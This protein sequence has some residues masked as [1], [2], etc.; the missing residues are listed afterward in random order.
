M[1][2]TNNLQQTL[3]AGATSLAFIAL[4]V[5]MVEAATIGLLGTTS[6]TALTTFLTNNGN[7]VVNLN[8]TPNFTGLD[9]VIL[10]RNSPTGATSTNLINFVQGGGRLIT[11]FT[12]SQWAL[13]QANLLQAQD[14]GG[15]NLGF[16][17][18]VT[19]TSEGISSGLANGVGVNNS[20][21]DGSR[22]EV[23]RNF[24]ITGSGVDVLATKPSTNPNAIIG[25]ASGLG[26]TLIIGYDWAD[27][28]GSA[29]ADT[30]RL[31][32]NA[33]NYTASTPQ[34]PEPAT[35]TGILV[36]GVAGLLATRKRS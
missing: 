18:P 27:S 2:Q 19:F 1:N 4:P 32:L 9:T 29:N 30:Q 36:F 21:S 26:T 16:S 5:S 13:N 15:S 11:E 6:N 17:T 31:I 23:F 3:L 24:N 34:V 33:L 12:G 14:I 20:Y 7:T 22:T 10:L 28:F 35:L 25:G 8:T